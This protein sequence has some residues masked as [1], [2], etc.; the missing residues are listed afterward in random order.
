MAPEDI[1]IDEAI[2]GTLEALSGAAHNATVWGGYYHQY[3][4]MSIYFRER[5]VQ[6]FDFP[7]IGAFLSM[8]KNSTVRGN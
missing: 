3:R 6:N 1:S 5:G 8:K 2:A 4:L 7:T